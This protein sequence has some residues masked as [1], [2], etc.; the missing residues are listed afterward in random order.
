MSGAADSYTLQER[1]A[2]RKKTKGG[3]HNR[4]NK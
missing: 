4:E 2:E 3:Q 1:T